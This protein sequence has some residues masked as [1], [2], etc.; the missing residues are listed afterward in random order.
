MTKRKNNLYS[1]KKNMIFN[2]KIK[3]LINMNIFVYL[4]KN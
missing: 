2:F 1:M 3:S 4:M